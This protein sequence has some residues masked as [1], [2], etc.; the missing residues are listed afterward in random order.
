MT[1][2]VGQ[3][4]CE[5]ANYLEIFINQADLMEHEYKGAIR[6]ILTNFKGEFCTMVGSTYKI[7]FAGT[8]TTYF[9]P[10][11]PVDFTIFSKP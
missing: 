2:D 4:S 3:I 10:S 5:I 11:A 1:W 8:S 6:D 9:L 7:P